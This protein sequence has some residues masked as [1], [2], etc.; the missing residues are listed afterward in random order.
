MQQSQN[1][2]V[3]PAPS[4]RKSN[5]DKQP[6]T[7]ADKLLRLPP[8]ERE[9]ILTYIQAVIDDDQEEADRI[10]AEVSQELRE[11]KAMQKAKQGGEK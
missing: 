5:T 2:R 10:K 4:T 9:R 7:I 6:E 1:S 11:A 3:S 8:A